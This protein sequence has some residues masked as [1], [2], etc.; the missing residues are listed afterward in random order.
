MMNLSLCFRKKE[1]DCKFRV[2][3]VH[4]NTNAFGTFFGRKQI[5]TTTT[6][7]LQLEIGCLIPVAA[8]ECRNYRI[9]TSMDFVCLADPY[10]SNDVNRFPKNGRGAP[11][12]P[13]NAGTS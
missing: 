12:A 10:N 8:P 9:A 6:S 1:D 13:N 11:S 5:L 7:C 4:E 2:L 3:E